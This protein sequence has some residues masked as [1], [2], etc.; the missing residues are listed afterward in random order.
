MKYDS[1]VK[2]S[3][4]KGGFK[5]LLF[6]LLNCAGGNEKAGIKPAYIPEL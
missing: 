4:T 2:R 1:Q 5:K 3:R 6:V